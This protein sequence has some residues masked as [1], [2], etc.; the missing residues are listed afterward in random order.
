MSVC[1]KIA[2]IMHHFAG[3][4]NFQSMNTD[5][6]CGQRVAGEKMLQEITGN[7]SPNMCMSVQPTLQQV[8]STLLRPATLRFYYLIYLLLV[9]P[10]VVKPNASITRLLPVVIILEGVD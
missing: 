10:R 7:P 3:F 6:I 2:P 4:L 9:Y 1:V 8:I 5:A